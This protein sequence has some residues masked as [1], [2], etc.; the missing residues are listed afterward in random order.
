MSTAFFCL[1]RHFWLF[2]PVYV[3]TSI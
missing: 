1:M 3:A 2:C